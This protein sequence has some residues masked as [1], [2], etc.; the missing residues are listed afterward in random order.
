[1]IYVFLAL[2]FIAAYL[3]MSK[4]YQLKYCKDTSAMLVYATVLPAVSWIF[5]FCVNGF[6]WEYSSFSLGIAFGLSVVTTFVNAVG[7]FV[8]KYC[9]LSLYM[10]FLMIGGMFVPFWYGVFFLNEELS[11]LRG[12][13][14]VVLIV[15]LLLPV[16]QKSE[17]RVSLKGIVMCVGVFLMNG[18]NSTFSKMHQINPAAVGTNDFMMWTHLFSF[19]EGLLIFIGYACFQRKKRVPEEV[20]LETATKKTTKAWCIQILLIVAI[21]VT[22]GISGIC[23]LTGA[24]LVDAVIL[25]PIVSGGVIY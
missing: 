16:L 13:A 18:M 19:V 14:M 11:L 2:F 12:I 21:S 4:G 5:Y 3:A 24:K 1:M 15:A 17:E 6:C 22:M 25:Y 10:A 23:N 8:M 20:D 7:L 9:K